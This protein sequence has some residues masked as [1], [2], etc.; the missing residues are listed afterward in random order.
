MTA[1]GLARGG[2][3]LV[4]LS[5]FGLALAAPSALSQVPLL[6]AA[7]STAFGGICHQDPSRALLVEGLP[8]LLC[9]RCL[10]T[11][12]GGAVAFL[13]PARLSK[14]FVL[15]VLTL[16]AAAWLAEAASGPWPAEARLLAGATIGLALAAPA[17]EACRPRVLC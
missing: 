17:A 2:A 4:I 3:A 10:G 13:L 15:A 6:L 8:S 14:K 16:G 12:A 9:A 7:L 5:L 1:A 11:F